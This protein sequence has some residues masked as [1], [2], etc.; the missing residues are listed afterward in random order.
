LLVDAPLAAQVPAK[1]ELEC[2]K[3]QYR[4]DSRGLHART[5]RRYR[6]ALSGQA[7]QA[8]ELIP[9]ASLEKLGRCGAGLEMVYVLADRDVRSDFAPKAR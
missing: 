3:D 1:D 4:Q 2:R 6:T 5:C 9:E 8:L 7:L